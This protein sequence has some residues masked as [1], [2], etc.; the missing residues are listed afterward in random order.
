M[1]S[2]EDARWLAEDAKWLAE[3]AKWLAVARQ[4]TGSREAFSSSF[5]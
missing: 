1:A 3:D 4:L 5:K 2:Q